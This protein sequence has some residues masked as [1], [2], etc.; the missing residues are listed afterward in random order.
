MK[1]WKCMVCGYIHEGEFPPEFCPV[2]KA[3][4]TKFVEIIQQT[5]TATDKKDQP[6]TGQ[7]YGFLSGLMTKLHFHPILAHIPNGVLPVAVCFLLLTLIFDPPGLGL[8]SFYNLIVVILAMPFVLFSGYID[9]KNRFN[10]ALTRIFITKM[11]CGALVFLTGILLI[12]WRMIEPAVAS[13]S[14]EHRFSYIV[15]HLILLGASGLA[16]FL[17]GKLVFKD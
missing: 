13:A 8:A 1:K 3:D 5:D 10:G 11:I 14:S 9:W 17:G 16:G 6:A 2:C 7:F 15:V 4:R 12:I